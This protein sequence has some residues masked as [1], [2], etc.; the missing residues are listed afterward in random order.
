MILKISIYEHGVRLI[1][2]MRLK[3]LITK[4][5]GIPLIALKTMAKFLCMSPMLNK[6]EKWYKVLE[7]SG[8]KTQFTSY[9]YSTEFR[10]LNKMVHMSHKENS[11]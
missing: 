9:L 10:W 11:C 2:F 7:D 4:N 3:I 5:K 1:F 6:K 8:K